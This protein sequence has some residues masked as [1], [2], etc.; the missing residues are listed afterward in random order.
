MKPV[1]LS[2]VVAGRNDNYGGDFNLRLQNFINWN[3]KLLEDY[4]ISSEII[5][6]NW[7]P[8][9]QNPSLNNL[10]KFPTTLKHVTIR[11][12]NVPNK[13]HQSF[14]DP[15]TR[16]TV[17][18]FEFIAKN[19]GILRSR[20][21][22]IL[23]TN[24]DVLIH[25]AIVKFI[26]ENR[27]NKNTFY[28]A[29]RL[30]FAKTETFTV[31][32]FFE[33][34][35][36]VSLVAFAYW[37]KQGFVSPKWQFTCFKAYNSLRIWFELFRFRNKRFFEKLRFSITYDNAAF[38]CHCNT[39]GDFM[40]MHSDHWN[41][42]KGYPEQTYVST[43]TDSLFTFM[44]FTHLKHEFVF[45]SPVF[46]QEHERRYTWQEIENEEK[47]LKMFHYFQHEAKQMLKKDAPIVYNT[48]S[49]GLKN[50]S[51]NEEIITSI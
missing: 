22:Y 26:A 15:K 3:S 30:D 28:R 8:V 32:T 39:S 21:E 12:I 50:Y 41:Y 44:A 27:L 25:P 18:L 4:G 29:H 9:E 36:V 2:I 1:Y 10:L 24:A 33:K 45:P 6:V 40:L 49:W 42:L 5:L 17:P 23:C 48:D 19:V 38:Y 43:H 46:H 14:I 37:F 31:N 13:I 20:G 35:T 51:L 16:F 7:N 34:A 11:I 47:F